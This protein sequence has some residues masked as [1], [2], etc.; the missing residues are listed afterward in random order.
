MWGEG[1]LIS[2]ALRTARVCPADSVYVLQ[3]A[4]WP[5]GGCEASLY[6]SVTGAKHEYDPTLSP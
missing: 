4:G 1:A 3:R 5:Q 6:Y 2:T